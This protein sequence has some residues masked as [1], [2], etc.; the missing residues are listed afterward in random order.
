MKKRRFRPLFIV[1]IAVPRDFEPSVG[2][3][4]GVYLYNLDNL[5]QVLENTAGARQAETEACEQIIAQA[6][7]QC[8]AEIQN[9]DFSE[10]IQLLRGHLNELGQMESQRISKRLLNAETDEH[11]QAILDEFT[12]RLI[13]KI[14]HRPLGELKN[15]RPAAAAMYATALRRLFALDGKIEDMTIP[16]QNVIKTLIEESTPTF[17]ILIVSINMIALDHVNLQFHPSVDSVNPCF[18]VKLQSHH[19]L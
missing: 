19:V 10:L 17:F 15:Q 1:D 18:H 8:Y 4:E 7:V 11:V 12:H 3:L 14:L 2:E 6:V 9:E 5:Q 16:E 13:N